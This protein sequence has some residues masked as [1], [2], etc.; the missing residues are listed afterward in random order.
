MEWSKEKRMKRNE[1]SLRDLWVT[2]KCTEIFFIGVLEGKARNVFRSIWKD[3][4][5]KL[6]F[7]AYSLGSVESPKEDKPKKEYTETLIN[8]TEKIK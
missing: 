5:F 3:N 6:T 1:D 2:I 8:Q 4:S 7:L